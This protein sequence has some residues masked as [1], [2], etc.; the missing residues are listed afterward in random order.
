MSSLNHVH[1]GQAMHY[2]SLPLRVKRRMITG[3][4]SPLYVLD[5]MMAWVPGKSSCTGLKAVLMPVTGQNRLWSPSLNSVCLYSVNHTT[6]SRSTTAR[7][8]CRAIIHRNPWFSQW[9]RGWRSHTTPSTQ[10]MLV[11]QYEFRQRIHKPAEAL[12]VLR[13]DTYK[14]SVIAYRDRAKTEHQIFH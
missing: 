3:R 14:K 6:P 2:T 5:S 12:H 8:A 13:E 4:R 11:P 10:Y 7:W 9:L 1:I